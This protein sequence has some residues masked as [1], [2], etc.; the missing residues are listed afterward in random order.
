M[1]YFWIYVSVV[2]GISNTYTLAEECSLSK[3]HL[4]FIEKP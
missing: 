3:G 1:D 2:Q 4:D